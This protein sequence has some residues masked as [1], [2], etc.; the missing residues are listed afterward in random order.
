MYGHILAPK[1]EVVNRTNKVMELQQSLCLELSLALELNFKKLTKL[2][3]TTYTIK[4]TKRR[5][6]TGGPLQLPLL[7][8][9]SLTTGVSFFCTMQT[10]PTVEYPCVIEH[11]NGADVITVLAALPKLNGAL[12][13]RT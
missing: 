7:G 1:C 10:K 13:L 6:Q 3:K 12:Q 2:E 11:Q 9:V 4:I 5:G 8:V